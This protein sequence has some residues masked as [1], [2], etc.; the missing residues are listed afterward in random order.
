MSTHHIFTWLC[1]FNFINQLSVHCDFIL[2]RPDPTQYCDEHE[3]HYIRGHITQISISRILQTSDQFPRDS[4]SQEQE[5]IEKCT[6]STGFRI[7]PS[8]T[9]PYIRNHGLNIA[10]R[11]E[12][13]NDHLGITKSTCFKSAS[14]ARRS[15]GNC[16]W[17]SDRVLP[18]LRFNK[19]ST[20]S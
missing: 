9:F 18:S 4:I 14:K 13:E 20:S 7:L 19:I 11:E 5:Q 6:R 12:L 16:T 15:R 8:F 17:H 2:V 10:M 3:K 1:M